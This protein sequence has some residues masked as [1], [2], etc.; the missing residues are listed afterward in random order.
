MNTIEKTK[1]LIL[2][3]L[4]ATSLYS[5]YDVYIRF[6]EHQNIDN[7]FTK[8]EVYDFSDDKYLAKQNIILCGEEYGIGSIIEKD[9]YNR[10]KN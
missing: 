5:I 10:C 6:V 2:S 3:L 9:L 7:L 1:A 8:T 4:L